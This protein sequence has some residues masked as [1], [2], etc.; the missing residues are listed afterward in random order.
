[1]IGAEKY[2][3]LEQ[4]LKNGI[5]EFKEDLTEKHGYTYENVG[6]LENLIKDSKKEIFDS[7]PKKVELENAKEET[8]KIKV[9]LEKQ[10]ENSE[11]ISE[12][13]KEKK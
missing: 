1:M 4:I 8:T 5:K 10:I 11:N 13:W 12:Y 9:E 2:S 3:K 7:T 6:I